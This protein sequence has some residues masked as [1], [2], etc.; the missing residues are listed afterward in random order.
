MAYG[1][2]SAARSPATAATTHGSSSSSGSGSSDSEQ[3]FTDACTRTDGVTPSDKGC[4]EGSN[5][6]SSRA[7]CAWPAAYIL[8]AEAQAAAGMPPEQVALTLLKAKEVLLLQQAALQSAPCLQQHQQEGAQEQE[9][10]QERGGTKDGGSGA[11]GKGLQHTKGSGQLL[12]GRGSGLL[13]GQVG[14]QL[15]VLQLQLVVE[16]LDRVASA[17]EQEAWEAVVQGGAQVGT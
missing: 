12:N 15:V 3:H 8:L 7:S 14:R 11:S 5:G 9:Q 10:E 16:R 1:P 2:T 6:S 4:T 13:A 17:L